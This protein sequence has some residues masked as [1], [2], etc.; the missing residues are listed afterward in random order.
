MLSW[1]LHTESEAKHLGQNQQFKTQ[2]LRFTVFAQNDRNGCCLDFL[3][4]LIR[5]RITGLDSKL[6]QQRFQLRISHGSC[7]F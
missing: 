1:G 4:S 6:T 5:A 7:Y 2:I 3:G